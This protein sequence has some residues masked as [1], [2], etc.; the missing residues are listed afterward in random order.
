MRQPKGCKKCA[1]LKTIQNISE[2]SKIIEI[3]VRTS[4]GRGHVIETNFQAMSKSLKRD[5]K[6][7]FLFFFFIIFQYFFP[8]GFWELQS[9]EPCQPLRPLQNGKVLFWAKSQCQHAGVRH[10]QNAKIRPRFS[11][12]K[13]LGFPFCRE[14]RVGSDPF[15]WFC[16]S[17]CIYK[18]LPPNGTTLI[19]ER[20]S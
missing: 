9:D 14:R 15:L 12:S 17:L 8:I 10:W 5:W 7:F 13:K 20:M 2:S 18:I 6:V 1:R 11:Y 3:Y 19:G 16:F 4:S